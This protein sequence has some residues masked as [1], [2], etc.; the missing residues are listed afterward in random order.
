MNTVEYLGCCFNHPSFTCQP[1]HSEDVSV[2]FK[3]LNFATNLPT[4]DY[5]RLTFKNHTECR[6][7]R[8]GL[9]N[10]SSSN[11]NTSAGA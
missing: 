7:Q 6:C 5:K 8:F 11:S 1:T 10:S 4:W 3:Q 2:L 9:S